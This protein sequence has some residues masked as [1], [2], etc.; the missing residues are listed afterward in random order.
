MTLM[1]HVGPFPTPSP[2]SVLGFLP[3]GNIYF[4]KETMVYCDFFLWEGHLEC[5]T[6]SLSSVWYT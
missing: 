6:L 3:T 5:Q 4:L 1:C 2:V